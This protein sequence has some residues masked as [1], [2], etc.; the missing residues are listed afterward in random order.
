MAV[1]AAAKHR[2]FYQS[3]IFRASLRNLHFG[4]VDIGQV[5]EILACH[6]VARSEHVA[7]EVVNV[8]IASDGAP[9]DVH[10][11]PTC[12]QIRIEIAVFVTLIIEHRLVVLVQRIHI[13]IGEQDQIIV[14]V[15]LHATH[16]S[17]VAA[18]VNITI[19]VAAAD[20]D[21]RAPVDTACRP[22]VA[23]CTLLR[24]VDASA[25]AIHVAVVFV[26]AS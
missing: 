14:L 26:C 11:C 13:A 6:A 4:I 1:L 3:G 25:C 8:C 7:V 9:S 22:A 21:R 15:S 18:T 2:A 19:D 24:V 12:Q 23:A 5:L 20:I 10:M 16:R 17:K